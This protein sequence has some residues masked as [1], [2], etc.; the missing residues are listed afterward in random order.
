MD[1][2]PLSTTANITGLLTFVTAVLASIYVRYRILRNGH[3]EIGNIFESV[4]ATIEDYQSTTSAS[5]ALYPEEDPDTKLLKTLLWSSYITELTIM[6][7]INHVYDTPSNPHLY[8][9]NG[10]PPVGITPTMWAKY[11]H[12]TAQLSLHSSRQA[13]AT[14]SSKIWLAATWIVTLGSTP[15][16]IRW[17]RVRDKVLEKVRQRETLRARFM[18]HQI[19]MMN[20]YVFVDLSSN[21]EN[22]TRL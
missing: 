4:A 22:L 7:Y 16:L 13:T 11:L 9:V 17:Y 19:F 8:M 2:T 18:F 12:E 5:T 6:A 10:A 1:D 3:T 15:R 20:L 21:V 14:C